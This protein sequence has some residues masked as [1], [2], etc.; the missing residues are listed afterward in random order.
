MANDLADALRNP[1]PR[2]TVSELADALRAGPEAALSIGS[3]MVAQPISGLAGLFGLGG[4]PES[5]A[6]AVGRVQDMLTY[7]PTNPYAQRVL[8]GVSEVT[9]PIGR[10]FEALRQKAGDAGYA[11]A[12]PV[13]GAIGSALPDAV[14]M[15]PLGALYR[16]LKGAPQAFPLP[17]Q[18]QAGA[19]VPYRTS[20]TEMTVPKSSMIGRDDLMK[21]RQLRDF[22]M[23]GFKAAQEGNPKIPPPLEIAPQELRDAWIKGW[24]RS[25][26]AHPSGGATIDQSTAMAKPRPQKWNIVDENGRVIAGGFKSAQAA[27]EFADAEVGVAFHVRPVGVKG[28]P[29]FLFDPNAPTQKALPK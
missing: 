25:G 4:G 27:D 26:M 22:E 2:W 28:A 20:S 29:E 9:A 10:A 5:A 21:M 6:N 17:N 19:I 24:E 23:S 11:V 8:S 15:L 1:K 14:S 13:G 18:S 7:Q 3:G 16:G 12:G